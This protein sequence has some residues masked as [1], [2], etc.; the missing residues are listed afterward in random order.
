MIDV[1]EIISR[2]DTP[3]AK[4]ITLGICN[5]I[6]SLINCLYYPMQNPQE[7]ETR[8]ILPSR[9]KF[10]IDD[11]RGFVKYAIAVMGSP[12]RLPPSSV[13]NTSI[14]A[15]YSKGEN[16]A[17]IKAVLSQPSIKDFLID[18]G[19]ERQL[20]FM[21]DLKLLNLIHGITLNGKYT[22]IWCL[23]NSR[24]CSR[25]AQLLVGNNCFESR[26]FRSNKLIIIT[27]VL[28]TMENRII[29]NFVTQ[30]RYLH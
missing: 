13:L 26:T 30:S 18:Q 4:N 17:T 27:Y 19:H 10:G 20:Q 5:N 29:P 1:K 23:W 14:I 24:E 6:P 15:M 9:V 3:H 28:S 2:E 21:G 8:N 11:G 16:Y 7:I 12:S 22:C 25:E